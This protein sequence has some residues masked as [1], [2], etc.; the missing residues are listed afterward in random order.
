M[1]DGAVI[2]VVVVVVDIGA[3]CIS[4]D[5]VTAV[6]EPVTR[7]YSCRRSMRVCVYVSLCC[8]WVGRDRESENEI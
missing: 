8:G 6:S 1:F 7:A 4:Y 2:V 3:A 5:V